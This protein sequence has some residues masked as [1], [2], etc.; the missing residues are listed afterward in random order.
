MGLLQFLRVFFSI[1]FLRK[2]HSLIVIQKICSNGFYANSLKLLLFFRPKNT[3]YDLDDAEYLRQG[4]KSLH[5]FLKKCERISVGSEALKTYCSTFNP[6][7]FL[8]TSPV[9]EH[10]QV[11]QARNLDPLHIGWVGDTGNGNAKAD[12]FSHKRSLF[13]LFFPEMLQL[14]IPVTLSLIGVKNKA[15]IPEIQAFF[16][17]AKH[18]ELVIP[19]DLAWQNDLWVYDKIIEFDIGISP[20]LDHPFNRAKS[21]FK[22]K[23][24]LSAG[25]PTIASDVGENKEFIQEGRTGFLCHKPGDFLAAMKHIAEMDDVSYQSMSKQAL[26]DRG[27]YNLRTFCET[28]L[29]WGNSK[30]G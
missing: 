2:K 9:V 19:T 12:G 1:L 5:H 30:I 11:K 17:E 28:I 10:G 21:A 8:L 26:A 4:T 6:H 15:D 3:L 16:K 13:E 25:V 18:V 24:Y 23:Q 7:V 27:S 29:A 22:I 14:Q 20:M